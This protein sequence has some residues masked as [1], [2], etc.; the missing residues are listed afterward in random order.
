M[1]IYAKQTRYHQ[2]AFEFPYNKETVLFCQLLRG[3]FGWQG[4]SFDAE[5]KAWVFSNPEIVQAIKERFPSTQISTEVIGASESLRLEEQEKEAAIKRSAELKTATDSDLKIPVKGELYPY[6]KVGVEFLVASGGRA[7]ITDEMGTGKSAQALGFVKY[8]GF[9]RTLIVCPASVKFSWKREVEKWTDLS[10]VVIDSKT[11]I[12]KIDLSV[13]VWIINYDIL[14]K[15]LSLLQKKVFQCII[16]DE[17]QYI[18]EPKA[19]RTRAFRAIAHGIPSVVLLSGTPLLSRPSELFSLLNI[20]DPKTWNNWWIYVSRYCSAHRTRWGLDTSGASHIDELHSKIKRYFIRRLKKDVLKELPPKVFINVPTQL[21]DKTAKEYDLAAEDLATYL[22]QYEGRQS[23]EIEKTLI[24]ERLS[25]RNVL[26]QLCAL[27]KL[28]T[29]VEI[30]EGVIDSGKKTLVFCSF[31]EPLVYL[32]EHFGSKAVMIT[33]QV[34]AAERGALVESFQTDPSVQVFL[35]GYKSAGTGIT[36]TAADTFI[37][38]DYPWNPADLSQAIDR[39]HR[40]GQTAESVNIYQ[41]EA[42]GTIDDDM[43]DTLDTKQEIFDRVIDGVMKQRREKTMVER[44]DRHILER[45]PRH[46]P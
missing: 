5:S 25:K 24:A 34:D 35:G 33:G 17:A 46:S 19:L 10:S 37:G 36:L 15:N 13:N 21:D 26:R 23:H 3:T 22:R 14:K 2:F 31:V 38:I 20:I 41:I 44:I 1:K 43:K 40:P 11:D 6:Q 16:G 28:P 30:I 4:I 8:C 32:K 12:Q 42:I 18:K 9:Q 45:Y 27:G 7:I 39:L 29:A